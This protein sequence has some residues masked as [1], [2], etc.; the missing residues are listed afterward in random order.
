MVKPTAPTRGMWLAVATAATWAVALVIS[1]FLLPVY[2]TA[3]YVSSGTDTGISP[4]PVPI[5][6]TVVEVN[7][8]AG[9]V[10]M[11]VPLLAALVVLAALRRG[12][13]RV[14]LIVAWTATG[15]LALFNLLALLSI[16]VL[17]IPATAALLVACLLATR[18]AHDSG[19]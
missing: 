13:H 18:V 3:T 5:T 14:S 9:A 17:M 15:F 16:G 1:A 4:G 12:V 8:L 11:A 7:G 10:A 19:T 6:Q 2:G